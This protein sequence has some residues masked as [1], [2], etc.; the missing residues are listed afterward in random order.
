MR[1]LW[2][3]VF[4]VY[5][6]SIEARQSINEFLALENSMH[7]LKEYRACFNRGP[8]LPTMISTKWIESTIAAKTSECNHLLDSY[9]LEVQ[10]YLLHGGLSKHEAASKARSQRI[11]AESEVRA[12]VEAYYQKLVGVDS[13][14]SKK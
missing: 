14:K 7:H 12:P 5:S 3:L 4:F 11:K 8:S 6:E 10:K 13:A 2:I 9:E 1:C